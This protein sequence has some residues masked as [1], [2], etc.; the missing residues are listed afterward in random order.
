MIATQQANSGKQGNKPVWAGLDLRLD[1]YALPQKIAYDRA[2]SQLSG[3]ARG[4]QIEFTLNT[5]GAVMKCDLTCGL[6]LSMSLPSRAFMGV[7]ARAYE[8]EDGSHTVTLELLHQDAELSIP[9]CV[10]DAV[11][12]TAADWHSWSKRLGLPMLLVDERGYATV[13]KDYAGVASL[14]PKPRRRRRSLMP[15]RPDFMRRR[16]VGVIGPV[17]RLHAREIIART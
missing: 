2:A 13:V 6:P 8:N 10:S 3:G 14:T 16:K 11:E 5:K 15:D 17:E 12:D 7:A 9:L 4:K 1:P